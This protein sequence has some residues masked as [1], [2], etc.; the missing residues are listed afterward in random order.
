MGLDI[1]KMLTPSKAFFYGIIL[2]NA[3]TPLGSVV[4]LVTFG[5]KD[6]YRTDYIKL[7]VADFDSSYH[8]ILGRSALAKFMAMP[9]FADLLLKMPGKTGILTLRG[10]LKKSYDCDHEAI[11]YATTSCMPE[12]SA[13]VLVATLKLTNTKMEISN[14]QPSQPRVKPNPSDIGIKVIQLQEGD[15]S[16]TALIGGGLG[17]NWEG[18]LARFLTANHDIFVWKPADMPGVPK[19][20]IE[21]CLKVDPKATPKK[22]RLQRFSPD[23]REAIKKEL[24]KLLAA[25]FIKEVYHPEWLDNPVLV[26]KKNDNEWRMCVDYTDLN[27]HCPKDPFALP[28]IN[29]VIDSTA[30]CVLLCFLYCYSGYHQIALKEEDQIKMVFIIPFGA[31]AYTT[32]PFGLKNAGVTY[33]RAIQLCL[34]DQLH[35]DVEAYVDDVIIKTRSHDEFISDLEETFNSLRRF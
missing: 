34:A 21:H 7:E 30:G 26:L 27:K 25:G 19:E 29:Q 18:A 35:R 33:Q 10:D 17:E 32:M 22:Q 16:K 9:H 15:P 3:A 23:K 11:K 2:G 4:L 1:S 14:Q 28:C 8:A 20:L 24:A 12:P 6:N 31:Y 5:T 13:E